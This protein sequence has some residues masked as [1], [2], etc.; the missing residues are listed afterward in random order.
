MSSAT[1]LVG[2]AGRSVGEVPFPKSRSCGSCD[3]AHAALERLPECDG[4]LR[5]FLEKRPRRL[6]L[7]EEEQKQHQ[8]DGLNGKKR[9]AEAPV[10]SIALAS[11]AMGSRSGPCRAD[12]RPV[13]R[14]EYTVEADDSGPTN[15]RSVEATRTAL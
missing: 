9:I 15:R 10:E 6:R 3:R 8:I 14:L 7:R 13:S 4:T 1:A 2:E 11:A 12:E 5:S